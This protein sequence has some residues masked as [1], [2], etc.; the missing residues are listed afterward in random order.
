MLGW[1]DISVPSNGE[2]RNPGGIKNSASHW[3]LGGQ[4]VG[5]RDKTEVVLIVVHPIIDG[6]PSGMGSQLP[7]G[8]PQALSVVH[9]VG[10]VGRRC[11]RE[12]VV[13]CQMKVVHHT[14]NWEG[15]L[16]GNLEGTKLKWCNQ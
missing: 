5:V 6:G 16:L 15:E 10:M 1:R 9:Q 2:W 11:Y 8:G 12:F 14:G 13:Y 3:E 4:D 7:G